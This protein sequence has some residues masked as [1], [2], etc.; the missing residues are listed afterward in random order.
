MTRALLCLTIVAAA[1]LG[2]QFEVA[3]SLAFTEGP[4]VDRDGNV[5]FTEIV[6]QRIMK[7]TPAGVMSVWRENSNVANGLLIDGQNRLVACEGATF[8]HAGGSVKGKPRVTRTDL[9]SGN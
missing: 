8:A 9:T 4:A 7:L 5:F 1:V 6:T 3:A 2:Q